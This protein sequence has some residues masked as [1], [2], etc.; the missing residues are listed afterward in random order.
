MFRRW[1]CIETMGENLWAFC[2]GV[3]LGR[4]FKEAGIDMIYAPW[5]RGTATTGLGCGQYCRAAVCHLRAG[6]Q[7]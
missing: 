4:R 7:S 1:R 2:A 6:R 3:Y 5:P